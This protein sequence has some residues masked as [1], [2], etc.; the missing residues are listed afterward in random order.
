MPDQDG[1]HLIQSSAQDD[2]ARELGAIQVICSQHLRQLQE[3]SRTQV[4]HLFET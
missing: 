1:D 3:R 4:Y 2:I